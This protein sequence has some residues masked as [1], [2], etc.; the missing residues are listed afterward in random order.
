METIGYVDN[1]I[2]MRNNIFR[3]KEN[4]FPNFFCDLVR[5]EMNTDVTIINAG[6]FRFN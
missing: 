1:D 2:E 3:I 4:E 5:A 6:Q